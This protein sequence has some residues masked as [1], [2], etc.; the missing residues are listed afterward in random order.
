M[1]APELGVL[2]SSPLMHG[3]AEGDLE[4]LLNT[5]ERR[6]Y[7]TGDR[8]V[9]EDTP[10]DCLFILAGGVVCVTKGTGEDAVELCVLEDSGEFFGEMS[11]IDILPRSASVVARGQTR[12]LAFPKRVLTTLFTQVPRVQMTLILNIARNLSL[13]LRDADEL[14]AKLALGGGTSGK[15]LL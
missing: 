10:S 15:G 13:R 4:A 7:E 11:L 2:R 9:E 14:I 5:A 6:L 3:M 8:I 1:S 12:I